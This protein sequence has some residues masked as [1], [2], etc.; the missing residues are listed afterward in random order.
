MSV[1]I[2]SRVVMPGSDDLV[3]EAWHLKEEINRREG[4]LK[5][6]YDFFTDAYRRSKVHCYVQAGELVGFASVR[7]DGYILFLAVSPDLRGEGIGKRLVARV[8]EDHDTVTCHARTTNENALQ[9]YEHLGFEIKR[10]IDDYYED[11]GDAYYLKLGSDVG[12]TD[13]ISDLMRR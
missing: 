8:A 11:S 5:Q 6:R 7:R 13:K 1:N 9:F 2:D 12:I 4:V 10:R 3:E